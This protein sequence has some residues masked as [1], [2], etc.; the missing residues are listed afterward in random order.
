MPTS[1]D[2]LRR[3]HLLSH[4][5]R[6]CTTLTFSSA[7]AALGRPDRPSSS[8]L[9]LSLPLNSAV[10]FFCAIRRLPPKGFHE[11]FVNLLGRHSFLTEVLDYHSDFMISSFSIL[12]TCRIPSLNSALH[13]QPIASITASFSHSQCPSIRSNDRL[14]KNL[15][16]AD[17]AKNIFI[18]PRA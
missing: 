17:R 14:T 12:Q 9:S 6:V 10:H 11:V 7:V 1:L 5:T 18:T 16:E 3:S 8:T 13:K 4:I 15:T 2:M